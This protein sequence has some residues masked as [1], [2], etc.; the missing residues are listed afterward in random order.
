M[1]GFCRNCGTPFDDATAFCGKCGS[2]TG[3]TPARPSAPPSAAPPA[4]RPPAPLQTPPA[5]A[6]PAPVPQAGAPAKSSSGCLKALVV[7]VVVLLILGAVAVAGVWYVAHR[8][9]E[10]AHEMGLDDL[11]NTNSNANRGPA[12]G[13]RDACSLLAKE[14]V[15]QAAKMEVVRAEATQGKGAGCMYSV[16]G[17]MTDLVAKHAALLPK[18][19]MSEQQRQQVESFAKTI[20]Q[21]ANSQRGGAVTEPAHPGE[22][23]VL[24]FTDDNQGAK[25]L[26]S[27]SR[28]TMGRMGPSLTNLPGIGDEAFDLAGVMIMARKG[29]QIMTMMYMACPCRTDDVVPLAKKIVANM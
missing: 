4:A 27:L 25:A 7:G 29:D 3:A 21:N 15:G 10:K 17:E 20:F 16:M 11:S 23:P 14:D 2:A 8:V 18:E 22:S 1:A 12:L 6:Q 24:L 19:N 9:K 28:M 26:M 13:G 5:P